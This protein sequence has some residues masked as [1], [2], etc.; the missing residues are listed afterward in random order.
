M[1]PTD[2]KRLLTSIEVAK[3]LTVCERTIWKWTAAGKFP[4]PLH[5]GGASRWVSKEVDEWIIAKASER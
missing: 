5:L 1:Q 3:E 2:C 4:K